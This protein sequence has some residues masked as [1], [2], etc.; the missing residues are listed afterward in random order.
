MLEAA[1]QALVA[2]GVES[3]TVGAIADQAGASKAT[4][5]SWY[6]GRDGL[7]VAVV[8]REAEQTAQDVAEAMSAPLDVRTRLIGLGR[9]LLTHLTGPRMIALHRAAMTSKPVAKAVLRAG[10][11]QVGP[12]IARGLHEWSRAGELEIDDATAATQVFYALCVRDIQM[13]S[14]IGDEP[15]NAAEI[16]S[17]AVFATDAFL[18]LYGPKGDP[19]AH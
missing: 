1:A 13:R 5:Y 3:L 2:H 15:P 10:L 14:L 6:G 9:T 8:D 17:G 4:I 19:A 11:D 12:V 7:L 16:T 18:A